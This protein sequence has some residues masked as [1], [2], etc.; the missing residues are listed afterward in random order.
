M[1][2]IKSYLL[3]NYPFISFKKSWELS[4][5]LMFQL[6][7][8]SAIIK[9]ISFLPLE[10]A[11]RTHLLKV[12][13]VKGALATTAIEGNTLTEEEVIAIADGENIEKSRHYMQ[14]EVTNVLNALNG[15][16]KDVVDDG[17]AYYITPDLIKSFHQQIGKELGDDF[18]AIPGRFRE[19]NVVVGRHRAPEYKYVTQLMNML[20]DWLKS[21]FRFHES[22]EQNFVEAIIE[23]IVAHVYI[24]WIHPFGDGNGRTA[25]LVEFYLLLRSGVPNICSHILSN[26]YNSTR[27]AYYRQLETAGAGGD[28]TKFIEYAIGGFIDGLENVLW[29]VQKHQ[30]QNAWKNYVYKVFGAISKMSQDRL[31]RLKSIALK[32]DIMEEYSIEQMKT[33]NVEIAAEYKNLSAR[34]V[35]RDFNL[36]SEL[37][38]IHLAAEGKYRANIQEL[39]SN[40]P[41]KRLIQ[42]IPAS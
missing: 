36:L 27:S 42:K 10:P 31:D 35:N 25:R 41:Q 16:F 17:K 22:Q 34:T 11:L 40:L 37:K 29:D 13:L 15:I 14:V 39:C 33:I 19:N 32:M 9:S 4:N 30:L 6:G 8:C 24:A 3:E 5:D 38:I 7:K 23:A 26:H 1:A 21:E 28:L 20:A 2:D 18:A 12:S